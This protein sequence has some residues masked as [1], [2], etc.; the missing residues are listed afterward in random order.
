ML[1][2]GEIVEHDPAGGPWGR[3]YLHARTPVS[4]T[5]WFFD[6]HFPNDPCMPG[7]LMFEGC[8]QAM[9]FHLTARGVT[10]DRDGWRFEPVPERAYRIRCRGQVTPA[11]R[12]LRYEVFVTGFSAG[13]EP[14][15]HADLL[16]TVD[17]LRAFHAADVGLRLVPDAA[18]S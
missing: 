4:P 6:G 1:L 12:E 9:A 8:L 5:D 16:C 11:S 15:L 7:T 3:G 13:P 2:L 10:V 17:G 14:T 18:G